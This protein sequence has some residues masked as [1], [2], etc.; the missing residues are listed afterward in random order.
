MTI[1][2]QSYDL[3]KVLGDNIEVDDNAVVEDGDEGAWVQARIYVPHDGKP[4][5]TMRLLLG[6]PALL[7]A[8]EYVHSFL[9][10]DY[11]E[12]TLKKRLANAIEEAKK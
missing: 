10:D 5:A 7:A 1:I 8:C 9:G 6:A 4:D 11:P 12:L 2:D 3:Y